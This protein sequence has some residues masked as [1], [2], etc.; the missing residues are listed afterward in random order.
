MVNVDFFSR[1]RR[2]EGSLFLIPPPRSPLFPLPSFHFP[3]FFPFPSFPFPFFLL[4]LSLFPLFVLSCT[5][6]TLLK[7]NIVDG[8]LWKISRDSVFG[9]TPYL[10][11]HHPPFSGAEWIFSDGPNQSKKT[12]VEI[13][14]DGEVMTDHPTLLITAPP[15]EMTHVPGTVTS[16]F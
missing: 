10:G 5:L 3:L 6:R 7:I 9:T 15:T 11:T 16:C 8:D 14:C 1:L 4:P 2:P 13:R 12:N